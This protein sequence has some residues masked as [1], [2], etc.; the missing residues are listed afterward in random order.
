LSAGRGYEFRVLARTA[1]GDSVFSATAS[2][3]TLSGRTTAPAS[4]AAAS[5][6]ASSVTLTWSA[7]VNLNGGTITDY[8]VQYRLAGSSTWTT[9][10]DSV[11]VSTGSTVTGLSAG[12]SYE[13]HVLARTAQGDSVFSA[14]ATRSTS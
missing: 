4:F 11:S 12:R 6:T 9:F 3:A 14:I 1:Q 10:N 8:R 5:A 2:R 7:P 13:F